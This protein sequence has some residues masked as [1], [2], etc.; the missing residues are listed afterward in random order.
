ME[1]RL[2]TRQLRRLLD[3][4]YIGNW[5]LNGPLGERR[6]RE[7]DEVESLVFS[8]AAANGMEDL[9]ELLDGEVVPSRS[10]ADGGIH[11]AIE[12]YENHEFFPILAEELA[13]RDMEYEQI[14]EEN[15]DELDSRV[16]RYLE[17]FERHGTDNI[18]IESGRPAG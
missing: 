3:M 1:I 11:T 16:D 6:I 15:T 5:V 13:L 12:A 9:A 8:C 7:Y 17:E 18:R 10:F 2:N 14:G 4:V